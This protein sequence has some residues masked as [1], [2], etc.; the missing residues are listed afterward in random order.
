MIATMTTTTDCPVDHAAASGL[1]RSI[2]GAGRRGSAGSAG[3][4]HCGVR[5]HVL[6][7]ASNDLR[8]TGEGSVWARRNSTDALARRGFPP[9]PAARSHTRR[10]RTA[11]VQGPGGRG[12]TRTRERA[13]RDRLTQRPERGSAVP[14]ARVPPGRIRPRSMWNGP[15]ST[16]RSLRL[17]V[18]RDSV[19][20]PTYSSSP[21]QSAPNSTISF[22]RAGPEGGPIGLRHRGEGPRVDADVVAFVDGDSDSDP[23][24]RTYKIP[25]SAPGI[26]RRTPEAT[27]TPILLRRRQQGLNVSQE[28]VGNARRISPHQG[29]LRSFAAAATNA[30]PGPASRSFRTGSL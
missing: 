20:G 12:R 15:P 16:S 6:Q 8:E 17:P 14:A 7:A 23:V 21:T 26:P 18:I 5:I 13:T 1:G 27:T 24:R 28:L 9:S 10:P 19:S 25:S 11:R 2:S 3:G 4:L 22:G 30:W 29:S